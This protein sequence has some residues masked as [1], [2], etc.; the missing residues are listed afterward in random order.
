MVQQSLNYSKELEKLMAQLEKESRVPSLLLHSCCAPCSSAVLEYLTGAFSVSLLYY[1]PCIFPESEYERR[2]RELKRL[3]EEMEFKNPVVII[4]CSY[5][6]EAFNAIAE[7]F[8]NA[9]EG[10][11]RCLK[12]Y[13]M[14]LREA[15]REARDG[16]FDYFASTLSISPMKNSAVLNRIGEE[17]AEEFG[18]KHLPSDFK[19][20]EGYKRSIQLSGKYNLY[21][22]DYCGCRYSKEERARDKERKNG[23]VS[24]I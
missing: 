21:R 3:V 23:N 11:E 10:G 19:K 20:K 15:A 9:R 22:Q 24:E 2:G 14:R 8:E 5:D 18:V 1:N 7:G 17:V 4:P 6:G 13:R 16:N 12:C